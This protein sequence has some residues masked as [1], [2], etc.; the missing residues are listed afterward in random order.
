VA[1]VINQAR[2]PLLISDN[3]VV[4]PEELSNYLDPN[5]RVVVRPRCYLC[6]AS[7]EGTVPAAD[8][9]G[10]GPAAEVFLLAPSRELQERVKAVAVGTGTQNRYRCIEVRDYCTSDWAMCPA[11]PGPEDESENARVFVECRLNLF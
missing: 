1:R 8:I 11:T 2:Y 5:I 7:P 10:T 6:T 4:Y 9:K 3:Y